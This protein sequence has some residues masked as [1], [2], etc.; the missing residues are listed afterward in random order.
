MSLRGRVT[1]ALQVAL[2]GLLLCAPVALS[3]WWSA[4]ACFLAVVLA[5]AMLAVRGA[6]RWIAAIPALVA[7]GSVGGA[8]LRVPV[9]VETW[10][11]EPSSV[12]SWGGVLT[13]ITP[14][15]CWMSS[16]LLAALVIAFRPRPTALPRM[17]WA[18]VA[19]SFAAC[20]AGFLG[21]VYGLRFTYG[22]GLGAFAT[23]ATIIAILCVAASVRRDV[24]P[25]DRFLV[26]LAALLAVSGAAVLD[27]WTE[28]FGFRCFGPVDDP[29]VR[30]SRKWR[31]FQDL[32]GTTSAGAGAVVTV[33]A[34]VAAARAPRKLLLASFAGVAAS[35]LIAIGLV[36][37]STT[38]FRG[39]MDELLV[40]WRTPLPAERARQRIPRSQVPV[41]N[42]VSHG[43]SDWP[44]VALL[45]GRPTLWDRKTGRPSA[46]DDARLRALVR[47]ASHRYEPAGVALLTGAGARM[48]AVFDLV[49]RV[50]AL[51][52][53]PTAFVVTTPV[54][55]DAFRFL[56]DSMTL[57]GLMRLGKEDSAFLLATQRTALM[58]VSL[59][60][61]LPPRVHPVE[62]DRIADASASIELRRVPVPAG[63][64]DAY[65]VA[66]PRSATVERTLRALTTATDS[67]FATAVLVPSAR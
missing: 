55:P 57:R 15:S 53:L 48:G 28:P 38:A 64:G 47:K 45:G 23:S 32:A 29:I 24:T 59:A 60:A 25:T 42:E 67:R 37:G 58:P 13:M 26:V 7:G 34:L 62:L 17:A 65:A 61:H 30:I 11:R 5:A 9:T 12:R 10:W 51:E 39:L 20:G 41:L 54:V 3:H 22:H 19:A 35:A 36:A 18:P 49:E 43:G 14:L 27:G 50:P 31:A 66:C 33:V 52:T 44:V 1:P 16:A 46:V 56:D 63:Y 21:G 40:P 4:A 8:L 6:V 2:P